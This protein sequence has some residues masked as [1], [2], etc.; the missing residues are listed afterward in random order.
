MYHTTA[1][2]PLHQGVCD[3]CRLP[4]VA[5]DD[6]RR[7]IVTV[8][9]RQYETTTAPLI[10]HY[11]ARGQLT[12]VDASGTPDDVFALTVRALALS[13]AGPGV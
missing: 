9:M 1:N 8:R 6:D 3:D 7:E 10:A 4:L 2:P 11:E 13:N 12:V 5:R